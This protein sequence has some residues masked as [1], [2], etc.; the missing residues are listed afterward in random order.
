MCFIIFE[1]AQRKVSNASLEDD[2]MLCSKVEHNRLAVIKISNDRQANF[3]ETIQHQ[4]FSI[5]ATE[6]RREN[7]KK[8]QKVAS[9]TIRG[10]FLVN[11][12]K[13]DI[14]EKLKERLFL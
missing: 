9:E 3:K 13:T 10:C 14:V 2:F 11:V 6:T 12:S 7:E 4:Y 5:A 1:N 8:R